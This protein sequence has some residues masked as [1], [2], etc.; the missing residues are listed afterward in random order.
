MK[1]LFN[2]NSVCVWDFKEVLKVDSD[3][4]CMILWMHLISLSGTLKNKWKF[5]NMNLSQ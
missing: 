5:L 1:L 4:G 2:N 3:D